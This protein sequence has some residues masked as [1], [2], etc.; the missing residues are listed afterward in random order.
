MKSFWFGIG[1]GLSVTVLAPALIRWVKG[2]SILRRL[3]RSRTFSPKEDVIM[4]TPDLDL[5]LIRKAEAVIRLRTSCI[6]VVVERCTNDHNYSAILRT[7]EALGIQ[8][9]WLID[10]PAM[11]DG[12]GVLEDCNKNG[13]PR[14]ITVKLSAEEIEQRKQHRLFAQ[15]AT[16]WLTI[17]DFK[18]TAECLAHCRETGHQ[19]WVTDL[20][21]KAV[22]LTKQ[23]LDDSGNWPF[24][25]K[26]AIVMGTESVGVSQEM[27]DN[28]DLRVYL[29]LRGYADSLNLSVATAL[30][31]HQLFILDPSVIGKMSEEDR[32]GLRKIWFPK[33]ARQRILTCSGKKL[34]KKLLARIH[35][36]DELQKRV[37]AGETLHAEQLQKIRKRSEYEAE[38]RALEDGANYSA[39]VV[40]QSIQ[41]L[42]YSP[43]EPLGDLRRADAHRVTFVGKAMKRTYRDH[44]KN[45][46][47][48]TH[49][50]TKEMSTASFF[51]DRLAA[52]VRGSEQ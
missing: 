34:R 22:P 23:G 19:V 7:A 26:I 5:R 42:I 45:L 33:L 38:L 51:R 30:V 40:D 25:S 27:L 3:E 29:P 13:Q 35:S 36:C 37:L 39:A 16:E 47:A 6:T 50:I 11:T 12:A 15:N 46:A 20:S 28:A 48:V 2:R 18:T 1:A 52:A 31:I 10:P 4:D 14:Q 43:P 21:Q 9:V 49:T 41:D 24:P 8:N 32:V 44:W 17:K